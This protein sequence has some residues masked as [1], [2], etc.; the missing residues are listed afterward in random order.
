[1]GRMP[2]I[3]EKDATGEVADI[4]DDI[5]RTLGIDFVPN[6]D[7]HVAISPNVLKATWNA[8]R[9]I[10][11]QSTLPQTIS[12]LIIFSVSRANDCYYCD[13]FFRSVCV[14]VGV[15]QDLL[16][17]LDKNP[18][19]LPSDRVKAIIEFALKCSMHREN[20]TDEDFEN[21]RNQGVTN[22]EIVQIVSLAGLCN[23]LNT[24]AIA[25]KVELDDTV[26]ESLERRES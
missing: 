5:R 18:D 6:I 3:E 24:M 20:P 2:L 15:D 7:K 12:S 13:S 11:L 14:A 16:D 1:M 17:K 19:S 10:Y 21:L 4:Y 23:Y 8:E 26:A 9:H 25:L 22:D